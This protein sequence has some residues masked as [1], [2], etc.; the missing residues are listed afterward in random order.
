MQHKTQS[1]GVTLAE[2]LVAITIIALLASVVF[3]AVSRARSKARD[4]K[5]AEDLKQVQIALEGYNDGHG[6]YPA[7]ATTSANSL[8]AIQGL[9]MRIPLDPRTGQNYK[10]FGVKIIESQNVVCDQGPCSSYVLEGDVENPTPNDNLLVVIKNS[11]GPGGT[12]N[13]TYASSTASGAVALNVIFTP[14]GQAT[15]GGPTSPPQALPVAGLGNGWSQYALPGFK[16]Q[17]WSSIVYGNGVYVAMGSNDTNQP[18]MTSP[19]GVAWTPHSIAGTSQGYTGVAFGDGKFVAVSSRGYAATSTDGIIWGRASIAQF[20]YNT[21]GVAYGGGVFVVV[22]GGQTGNGAVLTSTDGLTWI[23]RSTPVNPD[24]A[25]SGSWTSIAYSGVNFVAVASGLT[26]QDVMTSPDG[27]SWTLQ[28]T[29]TTNTLGIQSVGCSATVCVAMNTINYLP[30]ATQVLRSTDN[31]VTWTAYPMID[32][33]WASV[34][35][36]SFGFAAVCMNCGTAV[37][38]DGITWTLKSP[39]GGYDAI[40]NGYSG[41]VAVSN[42]ASGQDAITSS[43]GNTWTTRNTPVP[44]VWKRLSLANNR[45]F[46]VDGYGQMLS[47]SDAFTWMPIATPAPTSMAQSWSKV[48]YGNGVYVTIA[49]VN[50]A[51]K[52]VMTS[53][54]GVTWVLRAMPSSKTADVIIFANGKFVAITGGL[55]LVSSDGITWTVNTSTALNLAMFENVQDV[56]YGNSTYM[57]MLDTHAV[58]SPDAVTWTSYVAPNSRTAVVHDGTKFVSVGYYANDA[59]SLNG[60]SWGETAS[61]DTDENRYVGYDFGAYVAMTTWGDAS[62]SRDGVTWAPWTFSHGDRAQGL[63]VKNTNI[64]EYKIVALTEG[65]I[66]ISQ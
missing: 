65:Y 52:N 34:T 47:S 16:G 13:T 11:D 10:Y 12:P 35:A 21:S 41:A 23:R 9:G 29:P 22:S 28:S 4:A 37:S 19:D 14:L 30:G 24:S 31:G 5:R 7:T 60:T 20:D 61:T 57:A 50:S 17:I 36:T 49:S 59:T 63:V 62:F 6:G 46:V 42:Q 32:G 26:G 18:V 25:N 33:G 66:Y 44:Q 55:A 58:L 8:G 39:P 48:V 40:T 64:D 1:K 53:T 2:L 15:N 3:A 43:D 27:V 45:Y 54:D 56:T 38:S 51:G